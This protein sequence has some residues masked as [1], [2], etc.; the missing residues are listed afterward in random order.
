[1]SSFFTKIIGATKSLK[2]KQ[3]FFNFVPWRLRDSS[4]FAA[5]LAKAAFLIIAQLNIVETRAKK[6]AKS[7][8]I[9]IFKPLSYYKLIR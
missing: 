1:M 7:R 2:K 4:P 9:I 8:Y 3:G 6:R 5:K